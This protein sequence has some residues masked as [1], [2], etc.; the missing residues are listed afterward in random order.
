MLTILLT[1]HGHTDRSEPE[2]YLGQRLAA[3][4]TERGRSDARALAERL[5]ETS[6]DRIVCSPLGRAVETADILNAGRPTVVETD[7][8][9]TELDYGAWEGLTIEQIADRFPGEYELYDA[10]PSSHKVGGGESGSDVRDRSTTLIDELV[11]WAEQSD[12]ERTCLL[13]GHSSLNR[14][15]LAALLGVPLIDYRR[16]FVQDWANLTILRWPDRASGPQLELGNDQ[17]HLRA[18]SSAP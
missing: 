13:V 4:L 7:D 18:I 8:R 1:R 15:L 11:A 17:S 14:V 9:L 3:V 5:A 6:I 2:Q 16:R 12:A 10:D